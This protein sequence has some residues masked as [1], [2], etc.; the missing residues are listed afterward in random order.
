MPMQTGYR[1]SLASWQDCFENKR[2]D[3]TIYFESLGYVFFS[4]PIGVQVVHN[5]VR[6]YF[7]GGTV[8][9]MFCRLLLSRGWTGHV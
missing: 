8:V 1:L 5:L 2:C 7:L 9:T 3:L 4:S 6:L